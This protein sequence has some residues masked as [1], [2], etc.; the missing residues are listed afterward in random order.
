MQD[1]VLQTVVKIIVPFI[2]L[3]GIYIILHGHLSPGGGFAG[4]TIVASSF[5]LFALA[6]GV[7]AGFKRVPRL[8]AKWMES[9][10]GLLFVLLGIVGL[11]RGTA[12]LTNIDFLGQAG[13]LFSA[14][15]IPLLTIAIGLKV[16][17]TIITLF[18][19][20]LEEKKHG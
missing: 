3:Y 14:G 5:I 17:S 7:E 9:M 12:Y 10:G 6:N 19:N 2:Q 13:Q 11:A 15:L 20:L 4:G 8:A 16:C 1:L 18:Y